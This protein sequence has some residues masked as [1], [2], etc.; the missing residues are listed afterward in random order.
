M[1]YIY[2]R[3]GTKNYY[4]AYR[5]AQGKLVRRSAKTSDPNRARRFLNEV[6]LAVRR[7]QEA[8]S[9]SNE[10][11][12]GSE[13]DVIGQPTTEGELARLR[14]QIARV[15]AR[16][17]SCEW[18]I[19]RLIRSSRAKEATYRESAR[20]RAFIREVLELSI[21]ELDKLD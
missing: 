14:E 6:L 17:E 11:R 8:A 9:P 12:S 20:V 18:E 13:H 16:V 10:L 15:E 21:T 2:K 3:A 4:L 7:E 5:D 1:G 19:H